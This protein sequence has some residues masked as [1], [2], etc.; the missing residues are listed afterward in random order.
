M[1]TPRRPHGGSGIAALALAVVL[2]A[3]CT[4]NNRAKLDAQKAYMAGQQQAWAQY[5]Q[6]RP[7]TV[8]MVGPVRY[9]AIDWREDLT[10]VQAIIEAHY[11]L[12]GEP[13]IITL[14]RGQERVRFT[15]K[16]LLGGQDI[17]VVA[18]DVVELQP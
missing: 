2:A 10:L 18:G 11:E 16:Q 3:G 7:N 14:V 17:P 4:S 8:R 12:P 13:R 1:E 9:P 15:A 6:M 5:Q